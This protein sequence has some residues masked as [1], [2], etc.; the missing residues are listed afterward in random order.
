MATLYQVSPACPAP[1]LS[2][3]ALRGL[4]RSARR[5]EL[6]LLAHGVA[7]ERHVGSALL[8][9]PQLT[10]PASWGCC[11]AGTGG[12]A[13]PAYRLKSSIQRLFILSFYDGRLEALLDEVAHAG[14]AP[15][16]ASVKREIVRQHLQLQVFEAVPA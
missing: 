5:F 4:L 15:V 8:G 16:A 2:L 9:A 14:A 1:P 11:P 13:A 6:G 7:F 12:G 3:E 10:T